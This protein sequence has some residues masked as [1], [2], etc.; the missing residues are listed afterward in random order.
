MAT[1]QKHSSG[2]RCISHRAQQVNYGYFLGNHVFLPNV[3][4]WGLAA[5][6]LW[7]VSGGA[8]FGVCTKWFDLEKGWLV[9]GLYS[10]HLFPWLLPVDVQEWSDLLPFWIIYLI[11]C[12]TLNT[13]D[14]SILIIDNLYKKQF[15]LV[16]C[17]NILLFK[18][19]NFCYGLICMDIKMICERNPAGDHE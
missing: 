10:P 9:R 3:S 14:P 4:S 15:W 19:R 13:T 2:S 6:G 11:L 16:Y 12:R 7:C 1:S 17:Q 8:V 5:L 18:L